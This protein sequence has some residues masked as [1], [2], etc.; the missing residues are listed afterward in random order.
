MS[1]NF[2]L[3]HVSNLSVRNFRIFLLMYPGSLTAPAPGGECMMFVFDVCARATPPRTAA[4]GGAAQGG[5]GLTKPLRTAAPPPSA[6]ERE[7][8]PVQQPQTC[9]VMSP[10]ESSSE[11][12]E[13]AVRH[14]SSAGDPVCSVTCTPAGSMIPVIRSSASTSLRIFRH[15]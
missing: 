5:A 1:Q 15:V 3:F 12:A 4:G 11:A 10:A 6:P 9:V 13:L 14:T 7:R 8:R 2:R